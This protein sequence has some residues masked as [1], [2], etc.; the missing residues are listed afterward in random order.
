[1]TTLIICIVVLA[2]IA[3]GITGFGGAMLM[4]PPLSLLLGGGPAI[5]LVLALEVVAAFVMI[6]SIYADLPFRRLVLLAV[7]ACLT[8]PVGSAML[9][10]LDPSLSRR[11]IGAV[12]VIF[13]L[14]LIS[15]VRYL[16]RPTA[17]FSAAVA[18]LAGVL[19]GATSIG[20]PPVILLLLSGPD[21]APVTRAILT[22]FVSITSLIG[23]V[24]TLWVAGVEA[25][26]LPW[27]SALSVIYL[28][29]TFVGMKLFASLNGSTAR[30][31]SLS[32]MLIVGT[33][34][35]VLG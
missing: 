16:R 14:A 10:Y 13:S 27:A 35:I 33:L 7:P 25:P 22:V 30:I 12:V 31:I 32:L 11:L 5:A 23:L 4:T 3:R 21:P 9:A 8:V 29:S 17:T 1:L 18:A 26:P 24:T 28:G 20:A 15:G 6:P 34:A 19:L 2:G